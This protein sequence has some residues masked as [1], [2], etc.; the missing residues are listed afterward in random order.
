MRKAEIKDINEIKYIIDN[1]KRSLKEDG[2]DQWQ[3]DSMDYDF[4]RDE[5]NSKKAYV[6]EEEGEILSYAFLSDYKEPAYKKR[7]DDL[8][9]YRPLTIHTFAVKDEM[10]KKGVAMKFFID[11]IKY[12]GENSFD[13][14]RIDTHE[15]NVKMRG[16]INKM[17]FKI[18]GEIFID[19]EGKKKPRICYE[20][21]L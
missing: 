14:L 19:E 1:A 7:D 16:L 12:A 9:G 10:K 8:K 13:S 2:V 4:I 17:G 20:L 6:Y 15:D 11:I 3:I 18:V 5:I 21:L